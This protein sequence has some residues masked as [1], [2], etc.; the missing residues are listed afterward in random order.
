MKIALVSP[1]DFYWPGG[2]TAHIS[3]LASSFR[4][5]GHDVKILAPANDQN[6]SEQDLDLIRLGRPVPIPSGASIARVS[7]SFWLIPRLK[8]ILNENK[9]DVIHVHEPL[10]PLIPIS[11]LMF[12]KTLT[13][14][15]FH[16]F[17]GS[18]WRYIGSNLLLKKPFS[19]LHGLIA[20]SELAKN[21]V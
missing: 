9:F 18:N 17:H 7:L 21:Q 10:A 19:K 4:L 11:T 1:Y 13:I 6:E 15:T 12:S 2:V 20:V 16:A 14:G 3:H 8:K 5:L